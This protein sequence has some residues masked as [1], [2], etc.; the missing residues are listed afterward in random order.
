MN[1][2]M[3]TA[4]LIKDLDDQTEAMAD[5]AGELKAKPL[6]Q[7][8]RSPDPKPE[9]DLSPDAL[10]VKTMM[11]MSNA[12]IGRPALAFYADGMEHLERLVGSIKARCAWNEQND[13]ELGRELRDLKTL[14]KGTAW[15]K[16]LKQ[17]DIPLKR[18]RADDLIR[19]FEGKTTAP[20]MRKKRTERNRKHRAKAQS[21]DRDGKSSKQAKP[22]PTNGQERDLCAEVGGF[23]N[24]LLDFYPDF[25]NRLREWHANLP[26]ALEK[27]AQEALVERLHSASNGLTLL[28]QLLDAR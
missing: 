18:S 24:E 13:L 2:P 3:T 1:K 6:P 15:P 16:V 4:D 21:A 12:R 19:I 17:H 10:A 25:D 22:V 20:D 8:P 7:R 11:E 14:T 27:D 28:A 5:L 26:G 9:P 23:I